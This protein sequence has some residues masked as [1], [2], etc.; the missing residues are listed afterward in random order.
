M[1][2]HVVVWVKAVVHAACLL[3]FLYLLQ[4][5]HNGSLALEADPV[6]F[7]THFTGDWA[8]WIFAV[9]MPPDYATAAVA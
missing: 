6:N 4:K 2:A 1:S 8:L 5:Y 3:P 7:L 9:G